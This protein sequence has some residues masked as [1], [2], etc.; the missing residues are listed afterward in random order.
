MKRTRMKQTYTIAGISAV[1]IVLVAGFSYYWASGS[2]AEKNSEIS[3]LQSSLG[4]KDNEIGSLQ[5]QVENGQTFSTL[6]LKAMNHYVDA[7]YWRG[8]AHA[9]YGEAH[10]CYEDGFFLL[11]K[12]YWTSAKD[13]YSY[14][15]SE[16]EAAKA[17]FELAE[18]YAP[19][20][21]YRNLTTKYVLFMESGAKMMGYIYEASEYYASASDYYYQERWSQGDSQ[22]AIANERIAS[23]G[24]EVLIYN[25]LLAE[26][27]SLIEML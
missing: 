22:L 12:G 27:D 18:P 8:E 2:L 17:L 9:Y 4:E 16:Y 25:D 26:I 6:Y 1:A 5:G 15:R 10:D 24:N 3:L 14:S 23:H 13:S 21:T 11:A 7:D 20:E 19:N